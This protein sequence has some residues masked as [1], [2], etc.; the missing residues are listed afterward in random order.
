MIV[1][2]RSLFCMDRSTREKTVSNIVNVFPSVYPF[3]L[4]KALMS[5]AVSMNQ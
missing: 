3:M 4:P 5:K 2:G 1:E